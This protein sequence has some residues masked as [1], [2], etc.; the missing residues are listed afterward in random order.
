MCEVVLDDVRVV[1]RDAVVDRGGDLGHGLV[2]RWS[3]QADTEKIGHL[4][5]A[6][7]PDGV[8]SLH[9]LLV[10]GLARLRR[11]MTAVIVTPPAA[12]TETPT[13]TE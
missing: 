13:T 4:L 10:D 6:V 9:E 11:G 8:V 3:T 7:Q 5:A 12:A 1:L 2:A